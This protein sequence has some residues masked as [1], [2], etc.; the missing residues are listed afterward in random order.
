[1]LEI[2]VNSERYVEESEHGLATKTKSELRKEISD[3]AA[4]CSCFIL[5]LIYTDGESLMSNLTNAYLYTL[6]DA[7]WKPRSFDKSKE[8]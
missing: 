4:A 3:R 5:S 8:I 6:I 1:M 7:F 2:L